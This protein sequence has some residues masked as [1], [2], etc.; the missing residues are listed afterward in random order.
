MR[1]EA[2]RRIGHLYPKAPLPE[3]GEA[4]VIAWIWTLTVRSPDPAA[5][6]VQV[7]LASTFLLSTKEGRKAWIEP[8][9]DRTN[10]VYRF[11]V[12]AGPLAAESE[13]RLKVGTKAARGANFK[14]LLTGAPIHGDWI[15]AEGKAGRI[16]SRLMA[17]VVEGQRGREYISPSEAQETVSRLA[18]PS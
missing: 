15:K 7:P 5:R 16:G 8:V 12:N 9:V 10:G 4:T 13:A 14:C 18:I 1:D 2:E 6:G 3:G 17:I 11:E